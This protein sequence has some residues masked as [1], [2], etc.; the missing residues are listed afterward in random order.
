MNIEEKVV[1]INKRFRKMF[2][3]SADVAVIKKANSNNF[4]VKVRIDAKNVIGIEGMESYRHEINPDITKRFIDAF[5]IECTDEQFEK[6]FSEYIEP[7]VEFKNSKKYKIWENIFCKNNPDI[8]NG[9]QKSLFVRIDGDM[10]DYY[11]HIY[12]KNNGEYMKIL[13]KSL[14]NLNDLVDVFLIRYKSTTI[15]FSMLDETRLSVNIRMKD[16]KKYGIKPRK[17]KSYLILSEEETK[18]IIE[19]IDNCENIDKIKLLVACSILSKK[20]LIDEHLYKVFYSDI[21]LDEKTLNQV[22]KII[23]DRYKEIKK[24]HID[25]ITNSL[26]EL[27]ALKKEFLKCW[28]NNYI[29]KSADVF[30]EITSFTYLKKSCIEKHPL[31]IKFVSDILDIEVKL[32]SKYGNISTTNKDEIIEKINKTSDL[33]SDIA[34]IFRDYIDIR[35]YTK[36]KVIESFIKFYEEE[37]LR[38]KPIFNF[39]KRLL[40]KC[41]VYIDANARGFK[42][43]NAIINPD[44]LSNYKDEIDLEIDRAIEEIKLELNKKVEMLSVVRNDEKSKAIIDLI[45]EFPKKGITTYVAI[46]KGDSKKLNN[47]DYKKSSQFA[48]MSN[49]NERQISGL[50]D[51]LT[52]GRYIEKDEFKASFG[53]Y[54]GYVIDSNYKNFIKCLNQDV[55]VKKE[56]EKLLSSIRDKRG[57]LINPYNRKSKL[58]TAVVKSYKKDIDSV[59]MLILELEKENLSWIEKILSIAKQGIKN[60][61]SEDVVNLTSFLLDSDSY[62]NHEEEMINFILTIIT[63][64][65]KALFVLKQNFAKGKTK[66]LFKTIIERMDTKEKI[67]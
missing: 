39:E 5:D 51:N 1:E 64:E 11:R 61:T 28:D 50:I 13:K 60:V 15:N 14:R 41:E 34:L 56:K 6:L 9:E 58:S 10:E 43:N 48:K 20:D 57:N 44:N 62:K 17:I 67:S 38:Y 26:K 24:E 33:V 30:D 66:E 19:S 37:V 47:K 22:E 3:L 40:E 2:I 49:L 55:D 4:Y 42:V 65:Y 7:H 16:D 52:R 63:N 53:W 12:I 29:E 54:Y 27:G 25:K 31:A 8:Y 46:L 23:E 45:F 18:E 32:G 21:S 35:D 36:V 59:D